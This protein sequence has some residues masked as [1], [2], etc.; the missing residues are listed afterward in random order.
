MSS[1]FEL[2]AH[3]FWAQR[4]N[5]L[6]NLFFALTTQLFFCLFGSI[7][8]LAIDKVELMGR[9]VVINFLMCFL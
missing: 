8:G 7:M 3:Y 1:K 5:E 6:V 4:W 9:K 2:L